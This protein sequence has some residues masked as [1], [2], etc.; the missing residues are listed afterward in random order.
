M[1]FNINGF[2][3]LE[4]DAFCA[5]ADYDHIYQGMQETIDHISKFTKK[6][7]LQYPLPGLA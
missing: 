3:A 1:D 7:I 5:I 4:S 6:I 2:R